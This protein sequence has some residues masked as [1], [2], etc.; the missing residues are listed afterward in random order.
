[1][2][3]LS[4]CRRLDV[5]DE[6]LCLTEVDPF[7]RAKPQAQFFLFCAGIW[8]KDIAMSKRNETKRNDFEHGLTHR[9]LQLGVRKLARHTGQLKR[10]MR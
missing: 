2:W 4:A 6:I 9:Q 1:M 3:A 10:Y 7:L 8:G 5:F